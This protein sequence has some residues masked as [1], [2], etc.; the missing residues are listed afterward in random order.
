MHLFLL[1]TGGLIGGSLIPANRGAPPTTTRQIARQQ[2]I[3]APQR[4][5]F[6]QRLGKAMN[7]GIAARQD[8]DRSVAEYRGCIAAHPSN[9]CEGLQ[10]IMESD[11][12]FLASFNQPS[13]ST[14]IVIQEPGPQSQI[15]PPQWMPMP[16]QRQ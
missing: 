5:S 16:S 7:S 14:R 11:Q 6:L 9:A 12:R 13:S 3:G 15:V 1:I 8:Y 4:P 10:P 2:D